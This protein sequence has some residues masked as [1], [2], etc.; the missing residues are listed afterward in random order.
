MKR[1]LILSL[2]LTGALLGLKAQQGTR[3]TADFRFERG[4]Y[5][6]LEDWKAQL[7]V[8]PSE[9]IVDIEPDHS[10]FFQYLLAQEQFRY[11]RKG[12]IVYLKP[13]EMFGYSP[14]GTEMYYGAKYRF[15]VIGAICLLREVGQV[16]RYSSFM[17]PGETYEAQRQ[18]GSGKLYVLNFETGEFSRFKTCKLVS[19]FKK[20][21][22]V[23]QAFRAAKGKR[24]DRA[25]AFV[26]EYN[27]RNPIY[28]GE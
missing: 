22:E 6:S 15:E 20:D 12:E 16:D 2:I 10:K 3:Y 14:G 11:P 1:Y 7:P 13:D 23:Y 27:F 24:K 28:F 18:Q 25:L 5:P 8:K 19:L 9:I 26:K 17:K 21:P 4:V